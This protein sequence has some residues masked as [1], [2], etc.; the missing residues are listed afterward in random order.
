MKPKN[1]YFSF[2]FFIIV[3]CY[4]D[5]V[6]S[7]S[8]WSTKYINNIGGNY[9]R[10][11]QFVTPLTG[12][13][14][15]GNGTLVKTTDGG[16]TWT[17]VNLGSTNFLTTL[18]FIT[19][20]IGWV[21]GTNAIF[22]KTTN[23]GVSWTAQDISEL[24]T[25]QNLFFINSLTGYSTSA[26]TNGLSQLAKTT[27]GGT[28]WNVIATSS[29]AWGEIKFTSELTGWVEAPNYFAKTTDGGVTW[30]RLLFD[31]S[32]QDF[33]F[34]NN[35]TGWV[36]S[37]NVMKK[38]ID[39]GESW[40]VHVLP[41]AFPYS[42]KFLNQNTG[43]CVGTS[44]SGG[45]ICRTING[46]VNWIFQKVE[47]N[48]TY[49]DIFF[50]NDNTGWASGNSII[51]STQNGGLVFVSQ[52]S[53]EIPEHFSLKQNFPNPFNPVTSI[54]FDV[55][56]SDFVS[57]KVYNMQGSEI[58]SLVNE[59]MNAGTYEISFNAESLPSGVYFYTLQASDFKET[60][61]MMLVK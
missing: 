30:T 51:S 18:F 40:S 45:V 50:I 17:S 12:W 1:F 49:Y 20:N 2:L 43:W 57:L 53:S 15:G 11:V 35:Y 10:R 21:G 9:L 32:N 54:K 5:T 61:K 16:D 55:K 60:K 34:I 6:F 23:G 33:Y 56:K 8:V 29:F 4:Q 28:I 47:A 3:F 19:E 36:A 27:N 7:Q 25:I 42:V 58:K 31:G 22:M 39:G 46:G 44:A 41:I 24:Q 38:T 14:C 26:K 48:N 37:E 13:A 59:N 52:I